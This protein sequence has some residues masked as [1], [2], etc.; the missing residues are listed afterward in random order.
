MLK[1]TEDLISV[2]QVSPK[3]E[4]PHGTTGPHIKVCTEGVIMLPYDITE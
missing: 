1:E 2:S 3:I 4:I